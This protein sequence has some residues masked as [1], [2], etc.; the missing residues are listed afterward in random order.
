MATSSPFPSTPEGRKAYVVVIAATYPS[1]AFKQPPGSAGPHWR[2]RT[3]PHVGS[4]HLATV[5]NVNPDN[6]RRASGDCTT[7]GKINRTKLPVNAEGSQPSSSRTD[8]KAPDPLVDAPGRSTT[9]LA[10]LS[11]C[12]GTTRP[13][14]GPVLASS[15]RDPMRLKLYTAAFQSVTD[16]STPL[17]FDTTL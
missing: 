5:E 4:A 6:A 14:S 9:R 17:T 7:S 11:I 2:S 13:G 16:R 1:R 10:M 3:L 12:D 15:T 8:S